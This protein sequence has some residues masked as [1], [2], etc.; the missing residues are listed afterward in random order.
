M[1]WELWDTSR[2]SWEEWRSLLRRGL[3]GAGSFQIHCWS[4]ERQWI[5]LA[6]EYGTEKPAPWHWGTVIEGPVTPAFRA[7]LRISAAY[8]FLVWA[9]VQL[10]PELFV[11][12]FNSESQAL[13]ETGSWALRVYTAVLCLFCIQL[14]VQQAFL[15][16]GMAKASLF[17][18]CLRK[19]ILLIPLIY[20]L[21][22]WMENKVLAIFLAE[23][24]SDLI[25]VTVSLILFLVFFRREMARIEGPRP[26]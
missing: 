18:A 9:L 3:R 25:S 12:L 6:L 17:I 21:P 15:S 7:M 10:F 26:S 13:M 11:L 8:M 14:S 4:D 24:V 20:I 16:I 2:L 22:R 19:V 1:G 5:T 23:P